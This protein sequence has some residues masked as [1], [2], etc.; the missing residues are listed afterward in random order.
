[1]VIIKEAAG[2]A[3]GISIVPYAAQTIDTVAGALA[4]PGAFAVARLV[5]NG[6]GGWLLI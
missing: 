2:G 3:A 1:M 4:L 6:G 5:S